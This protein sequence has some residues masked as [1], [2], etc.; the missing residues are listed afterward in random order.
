[1][2]HIIKNI[3]CSQYFTTIHWKLLNIIENIERKNAGTIFQTYE[4]KYNI[5]NLQQLQE[6][7]TWH[8]VSFIDVLESTKY[9]NFII[10]HKNNYYLT[11]TLE[12]QWD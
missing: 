1:M 7:W 8:H 3:N 11:D 4:Q 2:I 12:V 10:F 9:E 6:I 5:R